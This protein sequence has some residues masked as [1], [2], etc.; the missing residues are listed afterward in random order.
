[1]YEKRQRQ[2]DSITAVIHGR[3]Q[4]T[5]AINIVR[6]WEDMMLLI[7]YIPATYLVTETIIR[8]PGRIPGTKYCIHLDEYL[9]TNI[10]RIR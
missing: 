3:R 5:G 4:L 8:I 7:E 2:S 9:L 6:L 1:M 10:Q